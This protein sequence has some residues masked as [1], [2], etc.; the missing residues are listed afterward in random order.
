MFW[1]NSNVSNADI[2]VDADNSSQSAATRAAFATIATFGVAGNALVT[3]VMVTQRRAFSSSTNRLIL[4]QSCIDLVS[5][6]LFILQKF[7][8]ELKLANIPSTPLGQ[9]YCRLWLT[10]YLLWSLWIMSTANFLLISLERYFA[11]CRRAV[12]RVYFK[13]EHLAIRVLLVWITGFAVEVYLPLMTRLTK[14][15]ECKMVRSGS[16]KQA[17]A[18]VL[19]F[20]LEY[21]LPLMV[22]TFC[23]TN[24][25]VLLYRRRKRRE[26]TSLFPGASMSSTTVSA[27]INTHRSFQKVQYNVLSTLLMMALSFAVFWSPVELDFLIFNLRGAD[28]SNAGAASD[29]IGSVVD[30]V[31][32]VDAGNYDIYTVCLLA[33]VCVNPFIFCFKYGHFRRQLKKT[34]QFHK[35]SCCSCCGHC[36]SKNADKT[37]VQEGG[38]EETLKMINAL[39]LL[40]TNRHREIQQ[41]NC[42]CP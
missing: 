29:D 16:A 18:G 11:T 36:C 14:D 17:F 25:I 15:G 21:L 34:V 9:I 30:H 33:N 22:I 10:E 20:L 32:D 31:D 27:Q 8:P 42:S 23:Y 35:V 7:T 38:S 24:I 13:R 40:R 6:L 19:I 28:V 37:S 3:Y 41:L 5:C 12:Y 26:A 2:L 39:P 1:I 4:H